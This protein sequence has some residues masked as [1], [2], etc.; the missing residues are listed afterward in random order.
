MSP[1]WWDMMRYA[2]EVADS[3]HLELAMHASDGFALAG[4]PWISPEMSMQKLVWSK[5]FVNG[6][7]PCDLQLPVP[8]ANEGY[9]KD[10]EVLAMPAPVAWERS[11]RNEEVVVTKDSANGWVGFTFARPFT[12]RTII[13]HTKSSN[14]QAQ[15]LWVETSDD[16]LVFRRVTRLESPRHGWQDGDAAITHT[17]KAARSRFFRLVYDKEGSEP[18]SEDLDA[19]KWKP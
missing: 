10:I 9:Y 18:G 16:G 1:A 19:A 15:R 13:V 8:E 7:R 5:E 11:S 17:I 12:C 3:L 2:M 14:Y 6:G 4:G